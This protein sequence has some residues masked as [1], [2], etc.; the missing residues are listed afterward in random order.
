M[1]CIAAACALCAAAY[2]APFVPEDRRLGAPRSADAA[3]STPDIIRA[4]QRGA[5]ATTCTDVTYPFLSQS[6][7]CVCG[8]TDPP[9][10][11]NIE[12][13]FVIV[14]F[15]KC[16]TT[17]LAEWLA[18]HPQVGALPKEDYFFGE[19]QTA[20]TVRRFKGRLRQLRA[21]NR[22]VTVI[23]FKDPKIV[24]SPGALLRLSYVPRVKVIVSLR[25]P[26]SSF[27]S[28]YAF[29]QK[30]AWQQPRILKLGT[31][32]CP[33]GSPY[34]RDYPL[35]FRAFLAGCDMDGV[36]L[37]NLN[38]ERIL[39]GGVLRAFAPQQLLITSTVAMKARP[40][41]VA[42]HLTTFLGVRRF[43]QKGGVL[44]TVSN[45]GDATL[46][47]R[48]RRSWCSSANDEVRFA[49][50]CHLVGT[51]GYDEMR[52]LLNLSFASAM[53]GMPLPLAD[54]CAGPS[55]RYEIGALRARCIRERTATTAA[56]DM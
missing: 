43:A 47:Q 15:M 27:L 39:H 4:W 12:L 56:D 9:C 31:V 32:R 38:L 51:Q 6:T 46:M 49:I 23:G 13:D 8:S 41:A 29:R 52:A 18:A 16:G 50:V 36:N 53:L 25:N 26:V 10:Y 7:D 20:D 42:D 14:G 5:W 22:A 2:I 19:A 3:L 21:H 54:P 48:V 33:P 28:F 35:P 40:A 45:P 37:R 24:V 11:A 30:P 1:H 17:T 55:A 34:A 44:S